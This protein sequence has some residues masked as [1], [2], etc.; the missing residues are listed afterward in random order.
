MKIISF[1]LLLTIFST[2]CKK[3]NDENTDL[4]NRYTNLSSQTLA[5]L[6][7]ARD[8]ST[9][10]LSLDS[11]LADG[12]VDI[13]VDVEHMGHHY[14]NNAIVDSI[15]DMHKPEILVYNRDENGKPYLVAVEYAVPL[16]FPK[17]EGFSGNA[18]SWKDDSGFPLWLLHA[19]VWAYNPEG[20]FNWTNS[21]V[22][23]H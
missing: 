6:R 19:W 21:L 1:A 8:A 2:S 13:S 22:H 18:D 3:N 4:L 9:R 11:A 16:T 20:A 17:P 10:Y 5:E 12:Y 14:M 15:F 23:L 7:H